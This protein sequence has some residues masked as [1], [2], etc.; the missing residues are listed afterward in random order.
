MYEIAISNTQERIDGVY[1]KGQRDMKSKILL[2]VWRKENM[3]N[4]SFVRE[5]GQHESLEFAIAALTIWESPE[6]D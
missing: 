2:M 1:R 4:E 6:A 3:T 5:Y